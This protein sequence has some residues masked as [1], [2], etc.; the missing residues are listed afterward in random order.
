MSKTKIAIAL[1]LAAT[2]LLIS[3]IS[4]ATVIVF[5]RVAVVNQPVQL[6]VRTKG[7]LMPMGG[8]RVM[9]S[10]GGT[11]LK[12]ILT[13]GDG[14][15]YL[16]YTPSDIG[17]LTIAAI[18]EDQRESGQLLVMSAHE[19][20]ILVDMETG[21]RGSAIA[22]RQREG[23]RRALVSLNRAYRVIYIYSLTG[24]SRNRQWLNSNGLPASAI[25]P[26]RNA[27]AIRTLER[28][29]IRIQAI[30]G[31]ARQLKAS[32]KAIPH[33]FSFEETK[34]GLQIDSWA[35]VLEALEINAPPASN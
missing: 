18:Y 31:S 21:L 34:E 4:D 5:D 1:S 22:L 10:V 23:S 11:R 26:W 28:L 12:Q 19:R 15:G 25:L 24:L 35:D 6:A 17:L 9:L 2:I 32:E 16:M 20:V 3:A 33:R 7:R 13:G 29:G 8:Q 30:V 27:A 14:Y